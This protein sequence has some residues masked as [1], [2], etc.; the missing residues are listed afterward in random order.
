MRTVFMS[1][2]RDGI[3]ECVSTV[4]CLPLPKLQQLIKVDPYI[5]G[6]FCRYTMY[7]QYNFAQIEDAQWNKAMH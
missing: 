4:M 6:K 5:M 7:M 1:I 2:N 3:T